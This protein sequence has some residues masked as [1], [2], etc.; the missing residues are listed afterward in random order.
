MPKLATVL[1]VWL[2]VK[3]DSL[4]MNLKRVFSQF[5]K[6]GNIQVVNLFA[7]ISERDIFGTWFPEI[8]PVPL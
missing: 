3:F 4:K 1:F 7:Q 8:G 2:R 6:V 5:G